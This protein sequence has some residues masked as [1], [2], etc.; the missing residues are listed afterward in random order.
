[1]E[2]VEVEQHLHSNLHQ[3]VEYLLLHGK[4]G[5]DSETEECIHLSSTDDEEE[6]EEESNLEVVVA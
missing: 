2:V 6:E 4:E 1:V 5:D 3:I